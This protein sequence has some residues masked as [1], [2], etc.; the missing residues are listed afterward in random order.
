M[1]VVF[2]TF[3]VY[4]TFINAL[5]FAAFGE[6]KRRAE[7]GA[8]RI[9]EA[10]LLILALIGGWPGAK[11]GQK[12]FRHKTRKQPFATLLNSVGYVLAGGMLIV[13]FAPWLGLDLE[14]PSLSTFLEALPSE[15]SPIM[16]HR[17]GPGSGD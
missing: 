15:S 10:Q 5:A 11:L 3:V 13:L 7:Q 9:S 14:I 1:T 6:D 4:G 17:F 8:W 12:R 16:P 2:L